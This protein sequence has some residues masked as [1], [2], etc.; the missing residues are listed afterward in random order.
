MKQDVINRPTFCVASLAVSL[1]ITW[2]EGQSI[3]LLCVS[4][5]NVECLSWRPT[6]VKF[7]MPLLVYAGKSCSEPLCFQLPSAIATTLPIAEHEFCRSGLLL[8]D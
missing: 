4:S 7:A 6:W 1:R 8:G 5:M 2:A 3:D